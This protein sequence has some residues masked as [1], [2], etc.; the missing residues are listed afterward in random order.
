MKVKKWYTR[1]GTFLLAVLTAFMIMP[2]MERDIQAITLPGDD[3]DY[4]EV[5]YSS[6][7]HKNFSINALDIKVNESTPIAYA[8]L[9]DG[10]RI[11]FSISWNYSD[12]SYSLDPNGNKIRRCIVIDLAEQCPALNFGDKIFPMSSDDGQIACHYIKNNKL[13]IAFKDDIGETGKQ[14]GASIDGILDITKLGTDGDNKILKLFDDNIPV[15]IYTEES[16]I[17]VSKSAQGSIGFDGS[18]YYQDYI[19]GVSG[20]AVYDNNTL[21]NVLITETVPDGCELVLL[22]SSIPGLSFS[23]SGNSYTASVASLSVGNQYYPVYQIKCRMK[24]PADKFTISGKNQVTADSDE[25]EPAS[26][27]A[28]VVFNAPSSEKT[29][30]YDKVTGK[31]LW[32]VTVSAGSISDGYITLN[33]IPGAHAGT[34]DSLPTY[35]SASGDGFTMNIPLSAFTDG[36]YTFTYYTT[37]SA[38]DQNS[39]ISLTAKNKVETYPKDFPELKHTKEGSAEI[40]SSIS[41]VTADKQFVS[42]TV[43]G[44]YRELVWSLE[45]N[46]PDTALTGIRITDTMTINNEWTSSNRPDDISDVGLNITHVTADGAPAPAGD[47]IAARA[48]TN[49]WNKEN[50]YIISCSDPNSYRGKTVKLTYK[51]Y[52]AE[53]DIADAQKIINKANVNVTTATA[54]TLTADDKAEKGFLSLSTFKTSFT[55]NEEQKSN[56]GITDDM[57]YPV[58][59]SVSLQKASDE[60]LA[61]GQV[62]TVTDTLSN[63]DLK[64]VGNTVKLCVTDSWSGNSPF[65]NE[66]NIYNGT[67][68]AVIAGNVLTVTITLDDALAAALNA[69]ANGSGYNLLN[70]GI[71]TD[72]TREKYTEYLND[73]QTHEVK[74][75]AVTEF[76]GKKSLGEATKQYTITSGNVIAKTVTGSPS[77]ISGQYAEYKIEINPEKAML[78]SGSPMTV[79]DTL[80]S[81]LTYVEGSVTVTPAGQCS[82]DEYD[83]AN[84]KLIFTIPD[85]TTCVITYKVKVKQITLNAQYS[86]DEIRSMFGNAVEISGKDGFDTQAFLDESVY[87]SEQTSTSDTGYSK[88][89]I[90][91]T[92]TWNNN[93][94]SIEAPSSIT[95]ILEQYQLTGKNGAVDTSKGENGKVDSKTIIITPD[96]NE[97]G[98][99]SYSAEGLIVEDR[100]GSES[101]HKF[102]K[103]K[104]AEVKIDGYTSAYSANGTDYTPSATLVSDTELDLTNTFTAP[105]EEVGTVVITKNWVGG[106][107]ESRPALDSRSIYL[108]NLSTN[109]VIYASA[110]SAD[111]QVFTFDDLPL[112]TY[113]RGSDDKLV[114]TPV[115]YRVE[116]NISGS[117][118]MSVE[119]SSDKTFVLDSRSNVTAPPRVLPV[120]KNLT[121][122]NT[123]AE[124]AFEVMISKR[125]INGTSELPGAVLE[126]YS[127]AGPDRTL[128]T[129]WTSG[130]YDRAI[131]LPAGDYVLVEKT[132]PE[133]YA[134]AEEILFTVNTD[135]TVSTGAETD[136]GVI[137]MRDDVLPEETTVVTT[138]V[139]EETTTTAPESTVTTAPEDTTAPESTVTTVPEDTTADNTSRST[140]SSS[141]AVTTANDKPVTSQIISVDTTVTTTY[142]F[143]YPAYFTT[144]KKPTTESGENVAAGAGMSAEKNE[145][146]ENTAAKVLFPTVLFLSSAFIGLALYSR[147]HRQK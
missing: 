28:A 45:I 77:D 35:A 6:S 119:G 95:I 111:E 26:D 13:Y 46:V 147:K 4:E 91:G 137:I 72:I 25:T 138:T 113:S 12:L 27:E 96:T 64:F 101:Q 36:K 136:N 20:S 11:K 87:R 83:S 22:D 93:G 84:K 16:Q 100:T 92:K 59:W 82:F 31:I 81:R 102:Y 3:Y 21:T 48:D 32:S 2:Q 60:A 65:K 62:I 38:A 34:V 143:D 110:Y 120:N 7:D 66:H 86:D 15:N 97:N 135:G 132:A 39:E 98:E 130:A 109:E 43:T 141:E 145:A 99:W 127:I 108:K 40:P 131:I 104:L 24:L 128:I 80:G 105:D 54:N 117:Y 78:N 122:T 114:R 53:D 68:N 44:N 74:N 115:K 85:K 50:K 10:D 57:N 88:I 14:G 49:D 47:W 75:K 121:V 61:A 42:D 79:T 89:N 133:G 118:I 116:E 125:T 90:S 112:Y 71:V 51:I 41:N 70:I 52:V 58:C 1:L 63:T 73:G 30:T 29:G 56:L 129:S 139:S 17:F 107:A 67:A 134:I 19:I 33:D 76:E 9:K 106:N 140:V 123:Y 103:W 144:T 69:K 126:V 124:N 5:V 37:V 146:S 18:R 142:P 8:E 23:A 94:F 55:P